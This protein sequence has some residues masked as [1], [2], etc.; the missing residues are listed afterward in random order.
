MVHAH[1]VPTAR[2][3]R[4][5]AAMSD[6]VVG[7]TNPGTLGS[8]Y[9]V[10]AFVIGQLIA[11]MQTV[12]LV[13]VISCSNDGGLS[14]VGRVVVQ[15]LVF[16]VSSM[17]IQPHGEISDVP[18][19]RLQGGTDAVILDPKPNDIGIAV[20]ASRDIANIKADP[21][22]AVAQGGATPGSA[23]QFDWA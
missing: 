22:G 14:P 17:Q 12:T 7:Q 3:L 9:N 18:Y 13:K 16:Q 1:D 20:F 19:F 11:K 15:P 5:Y 23:G 6:T 21:Q 10:L 4:D 8:E 2:R